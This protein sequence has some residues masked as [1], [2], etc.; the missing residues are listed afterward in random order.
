MDNDVSWRS[1]P[2]AIS[3]PAHK[4]STLSHSL[5]FLNVQYR[6]SCSFRYLHP[7]YQPIV[8]RHPRQTTKMSREAYVAPTAS[9]FQS[10]PGASSTTANATAADTAAGGPLT[11]YICGECTSKVELKRGDPIRCKECGHRVL[12]KER[13]K[14]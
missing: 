8:S 4:S 11:Q 10:T 5:L 12:Y 6:F 3:P 2:F 1:S 7:S 9:T 13:T 14:R